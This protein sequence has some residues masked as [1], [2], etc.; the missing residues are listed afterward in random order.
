MLRRFVLLCSALSPR[1]CVL[2]IT[3]GLFAAIVTAAT[4]SAE[5]KSDFP[6]APQVL[7][8]DTMAYFRLDNV[9]EIRED[10]P[11]TAMGKMFADPEVRP[12]VSN[13]YAMAADWADG[14]MEQ[15][16]MSLDNVL[17]IPHGQVALAIMP[18]RLGE[19][20]N[21]DE[22]QAEPKDESEEA[23][24][25]RLRLRRQRNASFCGVLIIDAGD[26]LENLKTLMV[27]FGEMAAKSNRTV[28]RKSKIVG[29]EVVT[30]MPS[31]EGRHPVEYFTTG[32]TMVIGIGERTAT[33]VLD[34]WLGRGEESTL[35]Q[36][37]E[38]V[39]LMSRCI[40]EEDTRPQATFYLD[41]AAIVER[42]MRRN[43][44]SSLVL[45]LV[46]TLGLQRLRGIG[47]SSFRGGEFF[48]DIIHL[49]VAIN[50]PRDG[51]FG[52]L[53]PVSGETQPPSW[54]PADAASY[55]TLNWRLDATLKNSESFIGTF[56]DGRTI[57]EAIIHPAETWSGVS[58][59]DELMPLLTGRYAL[60][61]RLEL[62]IQDG[63]MV[64][65]HAVEV[66][67]AGE[68]AALIER[69]REKRPQSLKLDTVSGHAIYRVQTP[70]QLSAEI[71][72]AESKGP[73][74]FMIDS[75]LI[76]T[77]GVKTAKELIATSGGLR[78]RLNDDLS[79]AQVAGELS[80]MLRGKEQF[81]MSFTRPDQWVRVGYEWIQSEAS[82]VDPDANAD[83][84]TTKL[85][86]AVGSSKLPPFEKLSKYFAPS[87]S[88]MYDE[89]NGIHFAA[90]ALRGEK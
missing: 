36:R 81:Q 35:S 54:V 12:L 44:A 89:P 55:T 63:G 66:R 85:R 76:V 8:G 38:F 31:R 32:S 29:I 80:G 72:M 74:L 5:E 34:Q 51:I 86:G 19:Q 33:G 49:H 62:P 48:E 56:T 64:S 57:D 7:P 90:Y 69:V 79:Y 3:A 43:M 84:W 47:G 23:I 20:K 17:A 53:R 70:G 1:L 22:D 83:R 16:G 2:A 10:W 61:R 71:E 77:T 27:Q 24:R 41:P 14:F 46:Q 9:R 13:T 75:W 50:P 88:F 21:D 73:L 78:A 26:N 87:G 60:V 6:G 45:P 37:D 40:G 52:L 11:E 67:D 42:L 68:M 4:A 39:S 28:I 15:F 65:T 18:R 82:K 30:W 58:I 59:R 25:R